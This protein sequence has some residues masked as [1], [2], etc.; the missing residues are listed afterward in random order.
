AVT[1]QHEF[2]SKEFLKFNSRILNYLA[3]QM[4][5][6][7]I[8]NQEV[9]AISFGPTDLAA[10]EWDESQTA[11]LEHNLDAYSAFLHFG[12]INQDKKWLKHAASLKKFNLAMWDD[13]RSHFWSGANLKNGVVNKE[14]LYLDNQ[15]WSLLALDKNSFKS[16][17]TK[18]ALALNCDE[19]MVEHEG[20]SGFMDSKPTRRPASSQFVWSEG[21]AGQILAMKRHNTVHNEALV[22]NG[23]KSQSFLNNIKKMKKSDGGI[24]YATPTSNPDFSSASSVAGTVWFYFA[25]NNINPFHL[26]HLN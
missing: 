13:S 10:T 17:N 1:Y 4:K 12:N 3:T 5:P 18:N 15:T 26:D 8:N 9:Q 6:V 14:E 11:A 21:T 19:L 2:E 16:L 25:S 24:A 23:L 20:I 7:K 22:C